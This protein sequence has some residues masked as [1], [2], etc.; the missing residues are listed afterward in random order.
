MQTYCEAM[1]F[2]RITHDP[3]VMGVQA[4]T[5]GFRITVLMII[6]LMASVESRQTILQGYATW[7]HQA[8]E[9]SLLAS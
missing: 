9:E 3:D 7:R 4:C 6:G 5:R 8:T 1:N 2:S